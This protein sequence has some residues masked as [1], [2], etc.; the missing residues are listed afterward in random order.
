MDQSRAKC[1]LFGVD[2]STFGCSEP[3][4]IVPVASSEYS[5]TDEDLAAMWP[6]GAGAPDDGA[7]TNGG[8]TSSSAGNRDRVRAASIR[9][10]AV[11]AVLGLSLLVALWALIEGGERD[12]WSR[13]AGLGLL[14]C[15]VFSAS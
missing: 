8:P 3:F 13:T 14:P 15:L 7:P 11:Y 5:R 2:R 10:I 6:P 1:A 9:R 4:R 12:L